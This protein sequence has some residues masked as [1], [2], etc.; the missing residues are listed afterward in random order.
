MLIM[1]WKQKKGMVVEV[2]SKLFQL[3][4]SLNN[5]YAY[6]VLQYWLSAKTPHKQD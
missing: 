4:D 2:G 5:A 3:S 6:S 1:G